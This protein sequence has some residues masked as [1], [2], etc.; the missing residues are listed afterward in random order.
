MKKIALVLTLAMLL[1][2]AVANAEITRG[3]DGFT[4]YI[5]IASDSYNEK[6]IITQ[7]NLQKIITPETP[8][9]ELLLA[10]YGHKD[11][12]NFILSNSLIEM[13][14]DDLPVYKLPVENYS[15][16]PV[17]GSYGRVVS[18]GQFALP[19]KSIVEIK[20]SKRIAFRVTM[21]DGTRY[22][23]VLPDAV[24]AEWKQVIALEK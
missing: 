13:R 24:L 18:K 2:M 8:Q 10:G 21:E 4:E 5:T 11:V 19:G 3:K 16:Q 1:G 7:V 23:Y 15:L 9:Y 12:R 14:V 20:N 6:A 17:P 22:V